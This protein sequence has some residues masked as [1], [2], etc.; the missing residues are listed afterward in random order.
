MDGWQEIYEPC[1]RLD[2]QVRIQANNETKN[3]NVLRF[4]G[5]IEVVSQYAEIISVVNAS[6]MTDVYADI[7]DGTNS[8][9][10]TKSAP[11]ADFSGLCAGSFFS[12]LGATTEEY[13]I[14]LANQ[15]RVGDVD[16]GDIGQ[17]FLIT[18]KYGVDNFI[19]FNFTT[20]TLLDFTM[21]VFFKYRIINGGS[22]N[23]I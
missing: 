13:T 14:N 6:N 7:W 3:L 9:N 23:F 22:L 21:K 15:N 8:K 2:A 17:A 19:R 4:T 5:T 1:E 11:G 12:K 18:A 20:N 10:L 16:P